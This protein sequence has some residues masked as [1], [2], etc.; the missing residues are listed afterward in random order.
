MKKIMVVIIAAV[1]TVAVNACA[2]SDITTLQG[3]VG[4]YV[5]LS[6]DAN[7]TTGYSWMIKSLPAGL[8]FVSDVYQQ[9]QECKKGMVGCGGEDVF[10][11]IAEKPGESTLTLI[12]GQ[13]FSQSG[14]K[15]KTIR[16]VIR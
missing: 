16:V 3:E 9:S 1:M 5:K 4:K 14:W 2:K 13:P 12:Y 8:I 6:L 15:E 10:H 7:P 11:F